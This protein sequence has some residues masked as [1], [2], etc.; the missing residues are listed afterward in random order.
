MASPSLAARLLSLPK[1]HPFL[2]GAS[3]S[4]VKTSFADWMVQKYVERREEIDVPRNLAFASFGLFYLG[5]VQYALYVPI[6]GRLFPGTAS[7][8][9]KPLAQK[10]ADKGG[11]AAVAAQTF[12]DQCVHHPF[13]YFPVF[14]A[15]REFAK[16]GD[17]VTAREKYVANFRDDVLALWKIWVPATVCNFAFSPMYMRIPVVAATS[18]VWTSVL[19]MM[20]GAGDETF[21]AALTDT[22]GSPVLLLRGLAKKALDPAKEHII[23]SATGEDKV[24]LVRD[25]TAAVH[26]AGGNVYESRMLRLGSDFTVMTLVEVAPGKPALALKD[27]VA[28]ELQGLTVYTKTT[29][30]P[31]NAAPTPLALH[32]FR[33]VAP[34][35]PGLLATVSDHF[36]HLGMNITTLKCDSRHL[37]EKGNAA[38]DDEHVPLF[39]LEASLSS[40]HSVDEAELSLGVEAL[41]RQLG[42]KEVS[43]VRVG[44]SVHSSSEATLGLRSLLD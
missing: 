26:K 12:L 34:D 4:C 41:G 7:F 43:I 29:K 35:A 25:L 37:P 8:A 36:A 15:V 27:A 28:Q 11:M 2:F 19:S 13:C 44:T 21:E 1:R 20:R 17:L 42:V 32:H 6:F 23:I 5:G 31:D 33:L 40:Q 38:T 9:A 16:G 24:G 22:G 39:V 3:V 10:L 18:L 14:Y 30:R